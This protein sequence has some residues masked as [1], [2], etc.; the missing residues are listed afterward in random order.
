MLV[1]NLYNYNIYKIDNINKKKNNYNYCRLIIRSIAVHVSQKLIKKMIR[2]QNL[3]FPIKFPVNPVDNRI[4]PLP[5]T[6][7]IEPI[8]IK[9]CKVL[10]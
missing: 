6:D 8:S 2:F 5:I 3:F 7:N 9:N 1:L 10:F 4:E